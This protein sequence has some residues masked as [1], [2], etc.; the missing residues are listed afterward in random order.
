MIDP[1]AAVII[2]AAAVWLTYFIAYWRGRAKGV[3]AER[4]RFMRKITGEIR[5]AQHHNPTAPPNS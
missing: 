3:Q 4:D 1:I 5:K 2:L